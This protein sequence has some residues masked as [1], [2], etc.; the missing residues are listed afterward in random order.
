MAGKVTMQ[1]EPY[2]ALT[3]LCFLR[4]FK[5]DHRAMQSLGDAVDRYEQEIEKQ[6]T[7]EHLDDA[8]IT[9][10]INQVIGREPTEGK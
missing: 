1:L 3:I 7:S 10:E 4:E 9:R 8:Y 6:I 5:Y 2:N